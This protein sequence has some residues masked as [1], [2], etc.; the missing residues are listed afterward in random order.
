MPKSKLITHYGQFWERTKMFTVKEGRVNTNELTWPDKKKPPIAGRGIYILY[1]GTTPVY[2]GLGTARFGIWKRLQSHTKGWLAYA[3][4]N[5]SWYVFKA[6]TKEDQIEAVEALLV[7]TIPG[8]LNGA[9]P[10]GQLGKKCFPGNAKTDVSNTL[11]KKNGDAD[12]K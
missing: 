4:D 7:A 12:T 3:W 2:V 1:R 6:G 11:W 9:Q 10:S 8:L 5:A